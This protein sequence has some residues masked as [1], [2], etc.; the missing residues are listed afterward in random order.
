[1]NSPETI[2]VRWISLEKVT[3]L[4]VIGE[5]SFS[6][7]AIFPHSL[8][9][10]N[11]LNNFYNPQITIDPNDISVFNGSSRSPRPDHGW[12]SVFP[13]SNGSMG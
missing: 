6:Y 5:N 10:F 2:D 3:P 8:S 11:S 1:V 9:G 12:N 13:R 7:L 4:L